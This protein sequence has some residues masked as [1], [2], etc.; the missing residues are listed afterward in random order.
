MKSLEDRIKAFLAKIGMEFKSSTDIRSTYEANLLD[1]AEKREAFLKTYQPSF[2]LRPS[3]AAQCGRRLYYELKNYYEKG[4][5][6]TEPLPLRTQRIFKAGE[7]FEGFELDQIASFHNMRI[8]HR[9]ERLLIAQLDGEDMYGSIDGIL[10]LD[11]KT[12]YLIDIKS[13]T[14]YKFKEIVKSKQPPIGYAGQLSLYGTSPGYKK[15][16]DEL[17][18]DEANRKAAIFFV[19]KDSLE[20]EIIEFV[21]DPKLASAIISRF[22]SIFSA[23]KEDAEPPRDFARIGSFPCSYCAFKDKCLSQDEDKALEVSDETLDKI[24]GLDEEEA[25]LEL[26]H[27]TGTSSSY[28]AP[29]G[30]RATIEPLTTKWKLSVDPSAEQESKNEL[31]KRRRPRLLKSRRAKD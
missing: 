23:Y 31:R 14:T 8:T 29:S 5:V 18:V 6:P 26:W 9:Q 24:C 25:I 17:G 21:P 28:V 22:K 16:M 15:L 10:W 30:R 19:N 3:S 4:S 20:F 1:R 13:I 2:P 7:L 11:D 27:G 12:P